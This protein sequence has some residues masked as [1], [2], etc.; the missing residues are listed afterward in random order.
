MVE[1]RVVVDE[2]GDL[3]REL[4]DAL[5][6]HADRV[7]ALVD[8]GQQ[9]L[10]VRQQSVDLLTAVAEH[11]DSEVKRLEALKDSIDWTDGDDLFFGRT[12]LEYGLRLG[13]MEAEWARRVA[14]EIDRRKIAKEKL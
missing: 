10:R 5:Q 12:A 8:R 9:G 3:G 4:A 13:A 1:V 11:A 2:A 14:V 6:Q 7:A